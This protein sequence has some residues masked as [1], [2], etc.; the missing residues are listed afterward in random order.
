ML[1]EL[2][3]LKVL[4][5]KENYLTYRKYIKI[6]KQDT[7]LF[8]LYSILDLH[9]QNYDIITIDDF[10]LLA[11]VNVDP[12]DIQKYSDIIDTL[13]TVDVSQTIVED[14][15]KLYKEKTLAHEIALKAISVT[16]GKS[17]FDSLLNIIEKPDNIEIENE[18]EFVSTDLQDLY[19]NHV[20]KRGLR[21]RLNTLNK[22][23]GSIRKGD[24]AFIFA[25]PETG[26]TTFLASEST[27]M[28]HQLSEEDGPILWFNNEEEGSKVQ[29]RIYQAALDKPLKDLFID[30]EKSK[31]EYYQYTK[32]KIK[33]I[34]RAILTKHEIEG[35]CKKY[36]PSLIIID[37]IDK[38]AGFIADREDLRLGS[39]YVWA[40]Q[41]AKT[42]CPV[43]GVTQA[44]GT[45]EGKKWLTMDNVSNAKTAKQAEADLILGIGAIHQE[46]LEYMRYINISKNKLFGDEDSDPRLRHGKLEVLI[47]PEVA[48]YKDFE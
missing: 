37:Q 14:I 21:W 26:K 28:A 35:F 43:I 47:D 32:D 3:L 1:P 31:T 20:Q 5:N 42:Y 7:E 6:A 34:D 9:I 19:T 23:V 48:R 2:I 17:N 29:L 41:I 30:V 13:R 24:F 8:Y 39:I 38:I 45:G 18:I 10:K 44:D 46:G 33:Q 27:Y 25:R 40:R 36:K 12:R 11:L 16:E 15:L 4:L 22:S